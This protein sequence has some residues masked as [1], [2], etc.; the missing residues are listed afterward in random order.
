MNLYY[1]QEV[2]DHRDISNAALWNAPTWANIEYDRLQFFIEEAERPRRAER[3]AIAISIG[4][5]LVCSPSKCSWP[6]GSERTT[7]HLQ[8]LHKTGLKLGASLLA[9][10]NAKDLA[11]GCSDLIVVLLEPSDKAE[12]DCYSAMKA[13]S[14][15][16]QLVDEVLV[17]SFAGQ[18]NVKNT[19]I[20]DRRPF[21]TAEITIQ[22]K[23]LKDNIKLD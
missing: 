16:L 5:P 8:E 4:M 3:N 13:S 12:K 1:N 7:V 17:I 18:R 6:K 2:G 21:R 11:T 9:R 22:P 23:H 14:R 19:I 20:L 10:E 15:A